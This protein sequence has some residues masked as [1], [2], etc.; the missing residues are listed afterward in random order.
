MLSERDRHFFQPKWRRVAITAFCTTWAAFEWY[1]QN[2]FW[3]MI[4]TGAAIYCYWEYFYKFEQN[5]SA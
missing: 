4:A 3:A 2:S 5:K 1:G